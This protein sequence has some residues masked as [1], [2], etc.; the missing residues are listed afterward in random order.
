MQKLIQF[1]SHD[2]LRDNQLKMQELVL[3][4]NY[5][6]NATPASTVVTIQ[7]P[8]ILMIETESTSASGT[9]DLST[10]TSTE[11]LTF[12]NAPDDSAGE[13]NALVR[14]GEKVRR[15]VSVEVK[16]KFTGA[17]IPTTQMTAP[18]DG[19]IGESTAGD[20]D[21]IAV[22]IDHGADL[23]SADLDL[24]MTLKFILD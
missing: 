8:S 13:Y 19:L 15:L 14:V 12:P 9:T 1:P 2:P 22:D 21:L 10:V 16:N 6:G 5:A 24:V 18:A 20:D 7:D 17:V 11:T 23:T 4:Y 3:E